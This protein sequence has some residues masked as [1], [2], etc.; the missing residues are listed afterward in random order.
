MLAQGDAR[1]VRVPVPP[2]LHGEAP[3]ERLR[4]LEVRAKRPI[5]RTLALHRRAR[6]LEARADKLV[7]KRYLVGVGEQL[8]LQGGG[9]YALD[10]RF[11]YVLDPH[12]GGISVRDADVEELFDFAR[13][14]TRLF[15]AS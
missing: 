8:A 14:G 3:L 11:A 4:T 7:L 1:V 5:P 12:E 9:I 15:V 10:G 6:V 2:R 13:A